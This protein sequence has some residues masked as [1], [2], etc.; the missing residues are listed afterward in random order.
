MFW[1]TISQ[2]IKVYALPKAELDII[3]LE[4][5]HPDV[6]PEHEAPRAQSKAKISEASVCPLMSGLR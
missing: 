1:V 5:V 6:D 4:T 2:E 3:K